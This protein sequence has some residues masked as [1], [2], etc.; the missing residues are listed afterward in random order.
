[1][2]ALSALALQMVIDAQKK[3]HHEDLLAELCTVKI[4]KDY[5]VRSKA[6][7][8]RKERLQR[9]EAAQRSTEDAAAEQASGSANGVDCD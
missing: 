4:C 6:Q 2:P 7:A 9:D 8:A 1:M 5:V 3:H